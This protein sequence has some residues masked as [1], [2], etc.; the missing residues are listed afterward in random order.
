MYNTAVD[1]K[2]EQ[3]SMYVYIILAVL[4]IE[5]KKLD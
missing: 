3:K 4:F 2:Y 1:T 5:I